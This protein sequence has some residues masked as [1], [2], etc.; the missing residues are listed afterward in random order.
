[1]S[2]DGA[3]MREHH[4]LISHCL[5]APRYNFLPLQFNAYYNAVNTQNGVS[6]G[7]IARASS[8]FIER[9]NCPFSR[10]ASGSLWQNFEQL[11]SY[12]S[13]NNSKLRALRIFGR[14]LILVCGFEYSF[15]IYCKLSGAREQDRCK[16]YLLGLRFKTVHK[17]YCNSNTVPMLNCIAFE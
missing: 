17:F 13:V 15:T 6:G 2:R 12:S 16:P 10:D 8:L 14:S 7:N 5:L 4:T 1:M 11:I 9:V 3:A